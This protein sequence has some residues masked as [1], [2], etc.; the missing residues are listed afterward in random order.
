MFMCV[1]MC[2][3]VQASRSQ[4]LTFRCS[5]LYFPRQSLSL[6]LEL[7]D[8]ARLTR[9]FAPLSFYKSAGGTGM[10]QWVNLLALEAEN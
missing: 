3:C 5:P 10:A 6:S 9:H 2:M 8:S 4:R 1:H 7:P